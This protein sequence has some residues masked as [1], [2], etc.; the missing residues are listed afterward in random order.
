[1]CLFWINLF[2]LIV[3]TVRGALEIGSSPPRL[4]PA[5]R[6]TTPEEW[7]ASPG[8]PKIYDDHETEM[9]S[10]VESPRL[11]S[12]ADIP[13]DAEMDEVEPQPEVIPETPQVP[14]DSQPQHLSP[15]PPAQP[16]RPRSPL[17]S[18]SNPLMQND[19]N[20]SAS[21]HT[22]IQA[23]SGSQQPSL[24][25]TPASAPFYDES[26]G[27]PSFVLPWTQNDD[28]PVAAPKSKA[29]ARTSP[30]KQAKKPPIPEKQPITLPSPEKQATPPPS[31]E[32]QATMPLGPIR[33]PAPPVA[34][35]PLQETK[36][37]A[38][39]PPRALA[40]GESVFQAIE[41]AFQQ[42]GPEEISLTPV[43]L[44]TPK[45][46]I[47]QAPPP[48]PR[49]KPPSKVIQ[50][51]LQ[52][53]SPSPLDR[54]AEATHTES[55][56]RRPFEVLNRKVPRPEV[57]PTREPV[58]GRSENGVPTMVL[59][60]ASDETKVS[61]PLK[62]NSSSQPVQSSQSIPSSQ[63]IPPS[64]RLS[65]SQVVSSSQVQHPAPQPNDSIAQDVDSV[66]VQVDQTVA[67]I[68]KD[69]DHTG[70]TQ[71][72]LEYASTQDENMVAVDAEPQNLVD[73]PPEVVVAMGEPL[74]S[75]HPQIAVIP[76]VESQQSIV[77]EEEVDELEDDSDVGDHRPVVKRKPKPASKSPA[78]AAKQPKSSK[79]APSPKPPKPASR[80]D[81]VAG[82]AP[83]RSPLPP[84]PIVLIERKRTPAIPTDERALTGQKRRFQTPPEE[85]FPISQPVKRSRINGHRAAQT[86]LQPKPSTPSPLPQEGQ[87]PVVLNTSRSTKGKG[88]AK[89]IKGLERIGTVENLEREEPE[90]VE[91]PVKK[92]A[93]DTGSK[94]KPSDAFSARD[95]SR[96]VKRQKVAEELEQRK[97]KKQLSFVDPEKLKRPFRK[98]QVRKASPQREATGVTTVKPP[99]A[100]QPEQDGRTSK[101]F[102]PQLYPEPDYPQVA[103][104]TPEKERPQRTIGAKRDVGN[105]AAV[106][107]NGHDPVRPRN[108][109]RKAGVFDRLARTQHP[110]PAKNVKKDLVATEPQSPAAR[111]LGSF[112]PDLN[113]PPLPGLPGGRLMNKQLR[114]ILIRT[115][116][117]RVREAK[118]AGQS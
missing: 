62:Q 1:M 90:V 49:S 33:E 8:G 6:A 28:P 103:T 27:G 65:S 101:Y 37:V 54:R 82:R 86:I 108:D 14:V 77:V 48:K 75:P 21:M 92:A 31:P 106:Q 74:T 12:V 97:P 43:V 20:S 78:K 19:P 109:S 41:M 26:S 38:K 16:P 98:P 51:S 7:P 93:P 15:P 69:Q 50:S 112:A 67:D 24:E 4:S 17:P 72:S 104:I 3:P 105:K 22:S 116:K 107:Q 53:P 10:D 117:V 35:K 52:G 95:D 73:K 42:G 118:A 94:R 99:A 83:S 29:E 70:N 110:K 64:D 39:K 18:S 66:V 89:G 79:P 111:K 9:S 114:E 36:T 45:V 46:T 23:V 34:S 87:D 76:E 56:V 63:L 59:I 80:A 57:G 60:P 85:G 88:R 84:K 96:N 47:A 2:V 40:F 81:P 58:R 32:K 102:N 68:E 100:T 13:Q 61:S 25:K 11:S 55:P 44:P 91:A 5:P 30:E 71:S 113:P 115:G